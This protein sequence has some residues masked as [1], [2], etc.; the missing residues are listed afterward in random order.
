MRFTLAELALQ[1][2]ADRC[3]VVL[4]R[5]TL[6]RRYLRQ[7]TLVTPFPLQIDSGY[8]Y[9]IVTPRDAQPRRA[10]SAFTDWLQ[11]QAREEDHGALETH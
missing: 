4:G 7:G 11:T 1:S 6:A 10:V 9:Y 5:T 8:A 2:A 3:G